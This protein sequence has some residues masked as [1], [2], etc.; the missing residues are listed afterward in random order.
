M[1]RPTLTADQFWAKVD[2]TPGHGP[3]GDCWPWT[4]HIGSRGYGMSVVPGTG[5][6]TTA[7]RVALILSGVKLEPGQQ[8]CHHCDYPPCCRPDHL[9]A[10]TPKENAADMRAKGRAAT[11]DR[12]G[13]R[14]CPERRARGER[15]NTAVLTDET[16]L[17]LRADRAAGATL[18]ALSRRFGV[19]QA[20]AHAAATGKTWKHVP[21]P[22]LEAVPA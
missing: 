11:G 2:K 21:M 19:S 16:V 17:R 20:A 9:F 12:N 22:A 6:A 15:M 14:T 4:G 3:N 7:H 10:G 1:G 5:K 8:G 13:Q 18:A